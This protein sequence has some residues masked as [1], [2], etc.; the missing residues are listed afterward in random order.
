MLGSCAFISGQTTSSYL[1]LWIFHPVSRGR[2]AGRVG[3]TD[4]EKTATIR[5]GF[6]VRGFEFPAGCRSLYLDRLRFIL[7]FT[8]CRVSRV[9]VT[10]RG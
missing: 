3:S 10:Q 5:R 6:S 7:E 4:F 1:S 2:A 9:F 8:F